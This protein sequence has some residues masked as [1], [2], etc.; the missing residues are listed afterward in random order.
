MP[1][2]TQ[3]S[4]GEQLPQVPVDERIGKVLV[5]GGGSSGWMAAT[6]LATVLS[7][8]I[9]VELVESDAIGIVGVGEAT[10]PPMQ[11]FNRMVQ[12]DERAFLAAT[13]GTFK[14]GIEFHNWGRQGDSYL[15]QFGLVGREIDAHVKLHHWWLLGRLAAQVDGRPYPAYQDLFMARALAR[16]DR[17]TPSGRDKQQVGNRYTHAYHFDANLYARHLRQVAEGRGA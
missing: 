16:E 1:I 11:G 13:Q 12:L 17:F 10:I 8:D 3:I 4:P 15:H 6:M 2:M 5:V 9:S 7:K 14:L